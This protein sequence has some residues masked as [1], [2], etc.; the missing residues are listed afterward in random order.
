MRCARRLPRTGGDFRARRLGLPPTMPGRPPRGP[1]PPAATVGPRGPGPI[2]PRSPEGRR[3]RGGGLPGVGDVRVRRPVLHRP[4]LPLFSKALDREAKARVSERSAEAD[5]TETEKG[6]RSSAPGPDRGRAGGG[7]RGRPA[8]HRRGCGITPRPPAAGGSTETSTPG[9]KALGVPNSLQ[10]CRLSANRSGVWAGRIASARRPGVEP[11]GFHPARG[12]N[13]RPN[14]A[15]GRSFRWDGSTRA[16]APGILPWRRGRPKPTC[17]PYDN[18]RELAA[19]AAWSLL[20]ARPAPTGVGTRLAPPRRAG[21]SRPSLRRDSW[22]PGR[23]LGPGAALSGA[24]RSR[25]RCLQPGVRGRSL[26]ISG[27]R[28]GGA[29]RSRAAPAPPSVPAAEA[30]GSGPAR[31]VGRSLR[32]PLA[33]P[34]SVGRSVRSRCSAAAPSGRSLG[35]PP[36]PLEDLRPKPWVPW[37]P[38]VLRPKPGVPGYVSGPP[39]EAG[40]PES[41]A[42]FRGPKPPDPGPPGGSRAE[43]VDPGRR[44][45]GCG[46]SRLLPFRVGPLQPEPGSPVG[47]ARVF[48]PE[49]SVP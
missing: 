43:A 9:P 36:A 10:S 18:R 37:L 42:R 24:G 46:R 30:A 33:F 26:A 49:P 22:P 2:L 23:S 15:R 17:S 45:G 48:W 19:E 35:G 12:R 3:S 32:S 29:G 8:H 21:R 34:G 25:L 16:E 20:P 7:V 14:L 6:R 38:R 4:P 5:R 40:V 44:G 13:L 31:S 1:G 28:V 27:H 41:S 11:A 39:A 47:I